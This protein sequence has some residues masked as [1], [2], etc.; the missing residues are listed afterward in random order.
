MV[1]ITEEQRKEIEDFAYRLI[2]PE[3]IAIITGIGKA[4]FLEELQN[5]ES[6][7]S[8]AYHKGLLISKAKLHEGIIKLA[9]AGSAPAQA[10]MQ[11]MIDQVSI[12]RL[13]NSL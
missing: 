5:E 2:A 3:E 10:Q 6:E 9:N 1:K 13:K 8:K 7:I 11:K 12:K 4:I